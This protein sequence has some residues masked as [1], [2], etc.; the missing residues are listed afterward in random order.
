MFKIARSSFITLRSHP[1]SKISRHG[2][3]KNI[4][5]PQHDDD[6]GTHV[7]ITYL[8]FWRD[9]KLKYWLKGTWDFQHGQASPEFFLRIEAREIEW[10]PLEP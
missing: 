10:G 4:L 1:P 8:H 6:D 9:L 7:T 2:E 3:S 5:F